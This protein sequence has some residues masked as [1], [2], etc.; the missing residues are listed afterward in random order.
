MMNSVVYAAFISYAGERGS[1][2]L[3]SREQEEW[4]RVVSAGN[5]G[6]AL[7]YLRSVPYYEQDACYK[8][9]LNAVRGVKK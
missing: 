6:A 3:H 5:V 7:T 1:R 8:L 9:L 2:G 4:Y